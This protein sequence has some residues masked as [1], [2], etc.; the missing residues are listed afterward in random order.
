MNVALA[1]KF[2][3]ASI[4]SEALLRLFILQMISESP[5]DGFQIVEK[6]TENRVALKIQGDGVIYGLLSQMEN[7]G[8]LQ[9]RWRESEGKMAKIYQLTEKGTELLRTDPGS[10]VELSGILNKAGSFG[11]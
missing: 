7:T 3:Q 11:R 9:G 8:A 10:S 4:L 2:N 1:Q 5:M 6:L